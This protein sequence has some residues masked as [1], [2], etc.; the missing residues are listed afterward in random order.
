MLG[1]FKTDDGYTLT[2]YSSLY[3]DYGLCIE[4]GED[5][6][7]NSPSCLANEAYGVDPPDD[8]DWAEW[9]ASG[10]EGEGVPWSADRWQECLKDEAL[11]LL[12]AYLDP[13]D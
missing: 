8:M 6:L 3:V 13:E 5:T 2:V 10:F 11:D 7:F 4:K 9:E 1:Q 12:E